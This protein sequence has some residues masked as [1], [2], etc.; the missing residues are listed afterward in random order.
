MLDAL[1]PDEELH[2]ATIAPPKISVDPQA[3]KRRARRKRGCKEVFGCTVY[4]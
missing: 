4:V 1:V 3:G 2:G